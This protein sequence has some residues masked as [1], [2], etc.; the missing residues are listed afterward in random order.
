MVNYSFWLL[1]SPK[2][3]PRP[4]D[5]FSDR[6]LPHSRQSTV[7]RKKK[8]LGTKLDQGPQIGTRI[9]FLWPQPQ[10]QSA[11]LVGPQG[12]HSRYLESVV[13]RAL[14]RKMYETWLCAN[15]NMFSSNVQYCVCTNMVP[16]F[17]SIIAAWRWKAA[18]TYWQLHEEK[19]LNDDMTCHCGPWLRAWLCSCLQNFVG[20]VRQYAHFWLTCGNWKQG[21]K[22]EPKTVPPK[23]KFSF[24]DPNFGRH[25][26]SP[27]WRRQNWKKSGRNPREILAACRRTTYRITS[28]CSQ[29][30]VATFTYVIV[31]S[32]KN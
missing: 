17:D 2:I 31:A 32:Y 27:F 4:V 6:H 11:P 18:V 22:V 16:A 15:I 8:G 10:R 24:T 30:V 20:L 3:S 14:A 25:F 9:H 26:W 13:P 1:C 23:V 21:P 7:T 12:Q 19:V 29:Q 5:T 28:S